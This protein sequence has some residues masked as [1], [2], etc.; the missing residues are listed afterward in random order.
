[1]TEPEGDPMSAEQAIERGWL[2]L[3][4][5]LLKKKSDPETEKWRE[6]DDRNNFGPGFFA[7]LEELGK[8]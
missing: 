4:R 5:N 6:I 3:R 2:K 8:S 7:L 1:M